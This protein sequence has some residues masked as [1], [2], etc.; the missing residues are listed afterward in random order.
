MK[1]SSASQSGELLERRQ[2]RHNLFFPLHFKYNSWRGAKTLT[3]KF[4]RIWKFSITPG[5]K[6]NNIYFLLINKGHTYID[7]GDEI[8]HIL[9]SWGQFPMRTTRWRKPQKYSDIIENTIIN[10][11]LSITTLFLVIFLW[12]QSSPFFCKCGSLQSLVQY[13]DLLLVRVE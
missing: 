13:Y 5:G 6:K 9:K 3:K 8:Q 11:K 7:F 1:V 10:V 12:F 4:R 2:H